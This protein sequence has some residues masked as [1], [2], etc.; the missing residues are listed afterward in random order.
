MLQA[1]PACYC[2]LCWGGVAGLGARLAVA[3]GCTG[4]GGALAAG[5]S[6]AVQCW[7]RPTHHHAS[8]ALLS[9]PLQRVLGPVLSSP[10]AGAALW[11]MVWLLRVLFAFA[12]A[13]VQR[14][15]IGTPP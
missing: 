12:G 14:I 15:R 8:P 5:A 7:A 10:L 6:G 11:C 13:R 1:V 3:L 9:S 4:G 2:K